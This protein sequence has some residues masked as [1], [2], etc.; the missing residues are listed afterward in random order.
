MVKIFIIMAF[1]ERHAGECNTDKISNRSNSS[2]SNCNN[3]HIKEGNINVIA[4]KDGR[5]ITV[6]SRNDDQRLLERS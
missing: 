3:K 1:N 2:N 4:N 6:K 5:G